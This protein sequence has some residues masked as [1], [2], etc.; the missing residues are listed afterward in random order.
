M[1]K[2]EYTCSKDYS[3]PLKDTKI[4]N[5]TEENICKINVNENDKDNSKE[6]SREDK[7]V[8]VNENEKIAIKENSNIE[9]VKELL[10]KNLHSVETINNKCS[11][12]QMDVV[13]PNVKE[14]M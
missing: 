6:Y 12:V 14:L 3:E 1:N 4:D 13:I 7:E 2:E 8:N 5:N 9:G 11:D 10:E